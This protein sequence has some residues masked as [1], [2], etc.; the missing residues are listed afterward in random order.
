[1][2][3]AMTDRLRVAHC[4]DIHLGTNGA[5]A[6][7]PCR[8]RFARALDAIRASRPDLMLLAGDLFD[9]NDVAGDT[10]AFAMDRLADLPFPV[11]M[12]PGNH[13]CL[14][15]GGIFARH[16]FG[17]IPNVTLLADPDG[18]FA[19]LRALGASVWGRG[20]VE[21]SRDFRPLDGAPPR[22]P[23]CRWHLGMGH[24][25][26]VPRGE[27]SERSSPVRMEDIEAA[28][29][30]YLALGHHHAAMELVTDRATA[31]YSGSP[32]DDV[33]R[34]PTWAL[35]ELSAAAAA[36]EIRRVA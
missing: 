8:A 17:A 26:F 29:F 14:A 18:G 4:S 32:T 34:G 7:D 23:G 16:D 22:P 12:I 6:G 31:A 33:G 25:I 15:V 2:L 21:H 5:G 35:V 13:D 36:L 28:G 27:T 3:D 20:M 11:V 30:D 9:T 1:M 10:V 19:V 24:G